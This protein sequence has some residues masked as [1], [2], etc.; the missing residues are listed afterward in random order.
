MTNWAYVLHVRHVHSQHARFKAHENIM[1]GDQMD[2]DFNT[3]N[4]LSPSLVFI[5]VVTSCSEA[6]RVSA[7][8]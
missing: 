5:L 6:R 2:M 8:R 1:H 7:A 4:F 3:H